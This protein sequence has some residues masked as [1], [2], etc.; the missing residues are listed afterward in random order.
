V[1]SGSACANS[2]APK[3]AKFHSLVEKV[4]V[5]ASKY[6]K[7]NFVDLGGVR[8]SGAAEPLGGV[9]HGARHYPISDIL[10]KIGSSLVV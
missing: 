6:K 4:F 9:A 1:R 2:T 5:R 8:V 10:A 7:R 3:S